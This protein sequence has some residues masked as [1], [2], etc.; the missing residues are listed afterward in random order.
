MVNKEV[1]KKK[2]WN[3]DFF[4]LWQGQLVSQMGT[5]AFNIAMM[6]WIKHITGSASLMGLVMMAAMIPSVIL[7]PIGG[8]VADR[9][10]RKK[11]IVVGDLINGL[12]VLGL[13]FL[14]FNYSANTELLLT[15]IFIVAVLGGI[16][17]AFFRPSV[18]AAIPDIVP[19]E[20]VAAGNSMNQMSVQ[21]STFLGQGIG[22][23]L[24]RILGAPVMFLVD[25]ITYLFSA[26]SESFI[27]I[28]QKLPKKS[29]NFKEEWDSFKIDLID[30]FQY[31][32][33]NS[34]MKSLFLAAAVLNFFMMPMI[35]L[36]PFYVENFLGVTA[37]WYGYLMAIF[38]VGS[39]IGYLIAGAV[40]V[41]GDRRKNFMISSLILTGL[42]LVVTVLVNAALLS[43]LLFLLFGIL[44]GYINV[45]ILTILQLSTPSRKR[46]RVFGLL[47]TISASV[48]PIAMGLA[49]IVFDLVNQNISLIFIFCGV[50]VTLISI[51]VSFNKNFRDYLAYEVE[52][53][54]KVEETFDDTPLK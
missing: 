6:F 24:F 18:T 1:D 32:W 51:I 42:I 13:A 37:D 4:L 23:V 20:K 14:M 53:A 19:D 52:G 3:K 34:G 46:G 15:S 2:L 49:G 38:G 41:S 12:A 36:L 47:Q 11:L 31:V 39:M 26:F 35:V 28:P 44:N 48:S 7:G 5:Q 9:I 30:G 25:G 17:A 21:L 45:N 54:G 16:I 43:L 10:S 8:T 22:G 40:K 27:D 29:K 50:I 33:K